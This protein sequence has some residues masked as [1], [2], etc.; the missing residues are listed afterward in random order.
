MKKGIGVR[1]FSY[2]GF[3]ICTSLATGVIARAQTN[4][5]FGSGALASV[6]SGTFDSAFGLN[7][8]NA[9]TTG[10][11]NTANGAD[12]LM[13]NTTGDFNTGIGSAAL[14]DNTDGSSNTAAGQSA[15]RNNTSGSENSAIGVQAW[16]PTRSAAGTPPRAWPRSGATPLEST[17]PQPESTRF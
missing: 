7:A 1:L 2:L 10:S 11:N 17:T 16:V 9:D 8:L 15:L 3:V 6:T 5:F 14:I 12:A 4:T 13:S